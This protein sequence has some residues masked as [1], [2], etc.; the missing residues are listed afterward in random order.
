MKI[1]MATIK[2]KLAPGGRVILTV[3]TANYPVTA[4]HYRHYT[5]ALLNSQV[6]SL[7]AIEHHEF[8]HDS[9]ARFL[10][11]LLVNRLFLLRSPRLAGLLFARYMRKYLH[12]SE[13]TAQHLLV[14]MR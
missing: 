2:S 9:K 7:F 5:L 11:F 3:P 1:E 14:V 4:K 13:R 8:L 6:G 10:S 12:A